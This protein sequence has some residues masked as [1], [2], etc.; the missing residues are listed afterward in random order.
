VHL[1][2]GGTSV[3]ATATTPVRELGQMV[4]PVAPVELTTRPVTVRVAIRPD[5]LQYI[6]TALSSTS[7]SK[8]ILTVEGITFDKT[9]EGHY[10][11][12][13][14]LP[15]GEQPSY[16]SAYFIGN[17]SFFGLE[18]ARA[19][20]GRADVTFDITRA[21]GTLKSAKSWNDAALSVTFIMRW[22]VDRSGRD[23][24]VP[25]GVRARFS[26]VTFAAIP[27]R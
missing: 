20:Q 23:L 18:A 25:S 8:L 11:V 15:A 22:L 17:L 14:N 26:N 9:P 21:I 19:H 5:A 4:A 6:Q 2:Q 12:Y 1:S 27:T 7:K 13:L 3:G 24:P 10:E 16:K